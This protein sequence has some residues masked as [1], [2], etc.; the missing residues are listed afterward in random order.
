MRFFYFKILLF[1]SNSII[2]SLSSIAQIWRNVG[3]G[4]D[5]EIRVLYSDSLSGKLYIGGGFEHIGGLRSWGI[6]SYDGTSF[7]SLQTGID[8]F[9][10]PSG[11]SGNVLAIE[12]YRNYLYAGGSFSSAG[13]VLTQCL[14]KWNG[15][16]WDS[17]PFI[18]GVVIDLKVFNDTLFVAGDFNL[19][20]PGASAG[21]AA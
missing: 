7:D 9:N 16:Y 2:F 10:D 17:V 12:R 21:A 20:E 18:N 5:N 15:Q 1:S 13:N 19:A 11:I 8:Y 14:A 6:A 4:S 3:S